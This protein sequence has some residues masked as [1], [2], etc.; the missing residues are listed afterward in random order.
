MKKIYLFLL[1]VSIF[2]IG[3]NAQVTIGSVKE[4]EKYSILEIDGNYGGVRLP[5]LTTAD[6]AALEAKFA[7]NTAGSEGLLIY[8]V[9]DSELQ[10]WDGVKWVSAKGSPEPWRV[11]GGSDEATSNTEDIYQMGW[12]TIGSADSIDSSV[13][14]KVTATDRG[15]LIPKLTEA[16]RD[17][18]KNP[19]DG[20]FIY[21]IDE[22]CVNYYN[23]EDQEWQS[24]C[25][26]M[27]KATISD[28]YCDDI[29]V[30]GNYIEGVETTV[31]ERINIPVEVTKIGSY[32]ITVTVTKNGV[33][34]GYTFIGSGTFMY[35]GRQTITL[36]A[37]GTPK[38]ADFN[39]TPPPTVGDNIQISVNGVDF[40]SCTDFVIPV[41]PALA[42]YSVTC[43]SAVVRGVYTM[44]PDQTNSDDATHYIEVTVNVSDLGAGNAASGWSAETT[45][46]SGVQFR[47]NGNFNST[48]IQTVRLYAVA[49][50]RATTLDPITLTMTFQTKN[51]AVDCSVVVRAAYTPKKIV[52]FGSNSSYGYNLYY[53]TSASRNFLGSV[54]NYGSLESSTVKMVTDF[55]APAGYTKVGAFSV[56]WDNVDADVNSTTVWNTIMT[57]KPDIVIIAYDANYINATGAS[58]IMKY[59]NAG[60]IVLHFAE[61]N[62]QYMVSQVFGIPYSSINADRASSGGEVITLPNFD[63]PIING[64]FQ[65]AGMKSLGGL[66]V[67]GDTERTLYYVSGL[68]QA[69]MII[70][71][72]N[73]SGSGY[74]SAF[75][76]TGQ[77]YCYFGEG[78]FFTNDNNGSWLNDH[79]EPF[80]TTHDYPGD[81]AYNEYRPAMRRVEAANYPNGAYNSF[82]FAN[83]LAWAIDVAQ[84]NGI[85]STGN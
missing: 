68:P 51:G 1:F 62:P 30:F 58:L 71:G 77:R 65:P 11:S 23:S 21:N 16:Q 72:Y 36:T 15:M 24:L 83:M 52:S 63:D 74:V 50:I 78:G 20:L 9:D 41:T 47:G 7:E 22:D 34:N 61:N 81:P 2:A 19:V 8:S 27:G 60:G 79:T 69:G 10:F 43:G 55:T 13:A 12:V 32:D 37:Q 84:F 82:Y 18:I 14:F 26:R 45:R 80:A 3:A 40:D 48:G 73:S 6:K 56:R 38:E 66:A 29:R 35:T 17:S 59:L 46:V 5:Q 31:N 54:Y 67:G 4:P 70:Y 75:R 44:L 49:G 28:V 39:P 33:D 25:G 64:P 76:A 85:N 57:E 42:D 53:P